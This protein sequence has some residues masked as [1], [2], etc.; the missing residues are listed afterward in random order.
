MARWTQGRDVPKL[1]YEP[2]L[3]PKGRGWHYLW[4]GGGFGMQV[5]LKGR[6]KWIQCGSRK[7][8]RTARWTS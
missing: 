6:R 5:F 2:A 1:K 4:E 3:D 7:N 8:A